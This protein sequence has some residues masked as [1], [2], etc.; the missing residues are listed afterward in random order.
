MM[1]LELKVKQYLAWH[2][3]RLKI[4]ITLLFKES[5]YNKLAAGT[6]KATI[7]HVR[8]PDAGFEPST[9]LF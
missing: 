2:M 4:E 1:T 6:D 9:L 5:S 3:K 7:V 8:V